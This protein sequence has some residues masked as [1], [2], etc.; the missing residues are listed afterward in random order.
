MPSAHNIKI[1]EEIGKKFQKAN[2]IYFTD[3]LGLNVVDITELRHQ[4]FNESVEYRVEKNTLIKLAAENNNI[5]GLDKFLLGPTAMAIT[6]GEPTAPARVLKNFTKD[7]N[8][9]EV[10]GILFEGKVL[11][12]DAFIRIAN[13]PSR[14]ELL[15]K[16]LATIQSPLTKLVNTLNSPMSG[17]VGVLTSLKDQKS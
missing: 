10:K 4:L 17:M 11:D 15:S 7:H 9:P 5:K 2:A 12:G 13:L 14:E 1:V 16:L 3:Y 8:K 6:Y